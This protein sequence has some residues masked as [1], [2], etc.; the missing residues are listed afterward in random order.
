MPCSF[1]LWSPPLLVT[2]LCSL[3]GRRSMMGGIEHDTSRRWLSPI[4]SVVFDHGDPAATATSTI[5]A[6][7]L[8][9]ACVDAPFSREG[10]NHRI[11]HCI[12]HCTPR[13]DH[14]FP[15]D[16]L[17]RSVKSRAIPDPAG[18]AVA[19]AFGW[20]PY[21]LHAVAHLSWAGSVLGR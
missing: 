19:N 7:V 3:A 10:S 6:L 11:N 2:Y 18:P 9:C 16:D 15:L 5:L 4:Q 20:D 13:T 8:A 1:R 21:N 12:N 14:R 17:H